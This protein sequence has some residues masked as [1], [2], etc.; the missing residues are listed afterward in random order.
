VERFSAPFRGLFRCSSARLDQKK[1]ARKQ[2]TI[3]LIGAYRKRDGRAWTGQIGRDPADHRAEA[4]AHTSTG[5]RD[6]LLFKTSV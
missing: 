5:G 6:L 3:S 2:R 4:D 1:T